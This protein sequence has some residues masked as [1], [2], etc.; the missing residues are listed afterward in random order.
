LPLIAVLL[1]SLTDFSCR[2]RLPLCR[3]RDAADLR[4]RD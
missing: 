1:L 4:E 2:V 3:R